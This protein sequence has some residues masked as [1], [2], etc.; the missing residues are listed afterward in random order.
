MS[1]DALN[2]AVT[3]LLSVGH[4]NITVTLAADAPVEMITAIRRALRDTEG[5]ADGSINLTLKGV[6]AIPDHSDNVQDQ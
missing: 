1:A 5:V 6:T 2:A 4:T 3:N